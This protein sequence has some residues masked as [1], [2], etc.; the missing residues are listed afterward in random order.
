MSAVL[1]LLSRI[2]CTIRDAGLLKC[3]LALAALIALPTVDAVAGGHTGQ[4]QLEWEI[5]ESFDDLLFVQI[6]EWRLDL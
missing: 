3:E 2:D 6:S 5:F 1:I 4:S